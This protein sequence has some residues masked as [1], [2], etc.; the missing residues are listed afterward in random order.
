MGPICTLII[1]LCCFT[2]VAEESASV[3][4][5][6]VLSDVARI[7]EEQLVA[8]GVFLM[9]RAGSIPDGHLEEPTDHYQEGYIQAL[10]DMN[11]YEYQVIITV[12]EH[13]VYILSLI[14]I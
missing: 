8:D 4:D 13:K 6:S 3:T 14:H 9:S 1:S 5:E 10:V 12:K 11:F 7:D 2:L